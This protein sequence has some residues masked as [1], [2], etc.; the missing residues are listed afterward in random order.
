MPYIWNKRLYKMKNHAF[1]SKMIYGLINQNT[2]KASIEIQF[3]AV[4]H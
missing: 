4:L 3:N 2:G 1:N